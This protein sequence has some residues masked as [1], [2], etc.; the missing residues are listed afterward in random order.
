[1]RCYTAFSTGQRTFIAC[2]IRQT[3]EKAAL[4]YDL[5]SVGVLLILWKRGCG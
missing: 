4:L 2:K 3:E 1:M 5:F